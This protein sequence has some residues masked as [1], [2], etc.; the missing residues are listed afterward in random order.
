MDPVTLK[1]C[2]IEL[3]LMA[4]EGEKWLLDNEEAQGPQPE[5]RKNLRRA[6]RRLQTIARAA[7][8]KTGIA[9]FGPSQVGKS[10]LI[11]AL[12]KPRRGKLMV[13]FQGKLLDFINQVNPTGGKETTGVVTRF[14]LDDPPR[15]PD[16]SLPVCLKIFSETDI[17]KILANTYFSE[18]QGAYRLDP[19]ELETALKDLSEK[20]GAPS[21]APSLD[22]MEDLKEYVESVSRNLKAGDDLTS[23]FWPAAVELAGR[24]E[25]EDR[26]RLFSFIWGGLSE[27]TSLYKVL[28]QAL[29]QLGFPETA[30]TSIKALYEEDVTPDGR[31]NSVL[32]V[33]RLL[34]ILDGNPTDAIPVVSLEGR[35]T[36]LARP[37]LCALIAELHAKVKESPGDFMNGADILDFPGYR[38]RSK[39]E[40]FRE[41]VK[42]ADEIK[43]CF[44]RGKVAYVF[45]RYSAM[46]EI[47]VMLLCIKD[48][49]M[50]IADLPEVVNRWIVDS[51]GATPEERWGKQVCL[52]M[53]LTFFNVHFQ[54]GEGE[55][56]LTKIWENRLTASISQPF[57]KSDWPKNWARRG[58]STIPFNNCYW[59]LNVFRSINFLNVNEVSLEDGA[60]R[61]LLPSQIASGEDQN[62]AYI[63]KGVRPE[64]EGWLAS[65]REAHHKTPL[66]RSFFRS[67]EE[68][69]EGA[70][71]SEDGG[72]AYII[73][74]LEPILRADIKTAQLR[75][76]AV[77][78]GK[79]LQDIV[80]FF[81]QGGSTEEETQNKRNLF[82]RVD[83]ALAKLGNPENI[84]RIHALKS[85]TPWHRFGLLLRDLTFSDDEC[86]EIFTRPEAL[87]GRRPEPAAGDP[88]P[89]DSQ[90][91]SK[92]AE[93]EPVTEDDIFKNLF[94]D[95]ESAAPP[96]D[97]APAPPAPESVREDDKARHYRRVLETEWQAALERV[98]ANPYKLRYYGFNPKDL[99]DM[100]LELKAGA[101]RLKL[102]PKIEDALREASK[103]ANVNQEANIWNLSRIA[104]AKLSDFVNYL[105]YSPRALPDPA[106]RTVSISTKTFTLFQKAE[107]K[108]EYPELP[109]LPPA[110][111]KPYH[112]DWRLALYQLMIDNVYFAERTYDIKENERLG[113]IKGKVDRSNGKLR[114]GLEPPKV[115]AAAGGEVVH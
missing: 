93:A 110:Y 79:V 82:K 72:C 104:S 83:S 90:A 50:E 46:K 88:P 97:G 11:S 8:T 81:Y 44:I 113:T 42:K 34:G 53:V 68:A 108:G 43:N 85:G 76:L 92:A 1:E 102:M 45:Q 84:D 112:R 29:S 18:G 69:W 52:F 57:D 2:A 115:K 10:T 27:F 77:K 49:N 65:L 28:Y 24:L 73:S 30:F 103:Y 86:Y 91:A 39:Y 71:S 111:E 14:S 67:P 106:A 5:E 89:A 26:A 48:S 4:R 70:V 99:K 66:V 13:D 74:K 78:E 109:D 59:L 62:T 32:H 25:I 100:I 35:K 60:E 95:D 20:T 96:S 41:A 7:G 6:G 101:A 16:D 107:I 37:V 51:H 22:D 87:S 63:A 15:S 23:M 38:S 56:D 55:S 19:K 9:V 105:G 94:G 12:A 58:G 61:L 98:A 80:S 40:N 33:D 3:R 47:T 31:K 21:R 114:E 75:S 64:M 36:N 54:R 17:L